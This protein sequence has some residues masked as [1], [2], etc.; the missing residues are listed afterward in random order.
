MATEA[1]PHLARIP[2]DRD[3]LLRLLE[4]SAKMP[5]A[6]TEQ[7]A[8]DMI[9]QAMHAAGWGSVLVNLYNDDW[10][11]T[12]SSYI[13][14]PDEEIAYLT[15]HA[16]SREQRAA[17]F[18]EDY[19]CFMISR[20]YFVPAERLGEL[21]SRELICPVDPGSNGDWK[22]EDS[23][24]VPMITRSGRVIGRISIDEPADGRRPDKETFHYLE[25]FADIAARTVQ[26]IRDANTSRRRQDLERSERRILRMVALGSPLRDVLEGICTV[27]EERARPG[28]IASVM[29][30]NND[31]DALTLAA[32][33]NAPEAVA[34]ALEGLSVRDGWGSCGTAAARA[35]PV[36]VSDIAR[37]PVWERHRDFALSNGIRAC[38][39][40][41]F[42]SETNEVIGTFG[43]SHTEVRTPSEDELKDI[44]WAGY[45]A[46]IVVARTAR[47]ERIAKSEA[48]LRS[49]LSDLRAVAWEAPIPNSPDDPWSSTFV[50]PYAEQL[51]GFPLEEW[52]QPDF[53]PEHIHPEDRQWA[54]DYCAGATARLEDHDFVYR[55]IAADG[56]SVWV[57]DFVTVEAEDGQPVRARGVIV[58]ITPVKESEEQLRRSLEREQLLRSELDHR[59]KNALTGLLGLI[60]SC[61]QRADTTDEMASAV[62]GR[63]EAMAR[64]HSLLSSQRWGA[65]ELS[66]VIRELV[67][68]GYPGALSCD[69]PPVDVPPRQATAFGMVVHE[70]LSNSVKHGALKNPE[71]MVMVSWEVEQQGAS[72]KKVPAPMDR[73]R[74]SSR[75]AARRAAARIETHRRLRLVRSRG[76]SSALLRQGKRRPHHHR[77]IRRPRAARRTRALRSITGARA[78]APFLPDFQLRSRPPCAKHRPAGLVPGGDR[79]EE[80]GG[81]LA[82]GDGFNRPRRLLAD[83][84]AGWCVRLRIDRSTR[85][86]LRRRAD[87]S[88]RSPP[89]RVPAPGVLPTRRTALPIPSVPP[90]RVHRSSTRPEPAPPHAYSETRPPTSP[91]AS[92]ALSRTHRRPPAVIAQQRTPLSLASCFLAYSRPARILPGVVSGS[93]ALDEFGEFRQPLGAALL[94]FRPVPHLQPVPRSHQNHFLPKPYQFQQ[95]VRDAHTTR[96]VHLHPRAQTEQRRLQLRLVLV[97][98]QCQRPRRRTRV[99]V[100]L[101]VQPDQTLPRRDREPRRPVLLR[102]PPAPNVGR[103]RQTTLRVDRVLV[104]ACEKHAC[105]P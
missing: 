36:I 88:R 42:F 85:A 62:R 55:M 34:C 75:G 31:R 67:P 5:D 4:A 35:E 58:D 13:N 74:R 28:A 30:V 18:G 37:D 89:Q 97:R 32:A 38:W 61:H 27:V 12:H 92:G 63:V 64:I 14:M 102:R 41:P 53:W 33:P 91:S 49:L 77:R 48:E 103:Y 6:R 24:W 81:L 44:E 101:R 98:C 56:R 76:R 46:S 51:L 52:Y 94:P 71:G 96:R 86:G 2:S 99:E 29:L 23:A 17:T 72:E 50:S 105:S 65:I 95:I 3:R 69:G 83:R 70:L 47:D 22:A 20:S 9:G 26:D 15:Q 40:I 19:A 79:G 78:A 68:L 45:L 60:D 7:E 39:S 84:A 90:R 80:G 59:V 57:R 1:T 54:I 21:P 43:I 100:P 10:E 66:T 11:V 104:L 82:A 8:I 25:A 16:M 73:V 93:D 87:H